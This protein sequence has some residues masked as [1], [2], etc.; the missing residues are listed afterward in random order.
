LQ[1]EFHIGLQTTANI[2]L[3]QH[4]AI[5]ISR[6][7]LGRAKFR[8]DYGSEPA[9]TWVS[10]QTGHTVIVA[11]NVYARG[12]EEAPGHVA[13]AR[14]EFRALSRSW[15]TFLGFGMFLGVLPPNSLKRARD[16]GVGLEL[17]QEQEWEWEQEQKK[18][19]CLK[20][21]DIEAEVQ[22][23]VEQKLYKGAWQH[24]YKKLEIIDYS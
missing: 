12:I 1:Y 18:R 24:L 23:R 21:V 3:W 13:S 6:R 17:N 7:H 5:A 15:H 22:I 20:E 14:A 19:A 16:S 2:T 9:P 11:G 8:R 10:E 4:I